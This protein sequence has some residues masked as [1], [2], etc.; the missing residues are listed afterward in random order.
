MIWYLPKVYSNI[1]CETNEMQLHLSNQPGKATHVTAKVPFDTGY[2]TCIHNAFC[3]EF[4]SIIIITC[5]TC[6]CVSTYVRL[7][8]KCTYVL[9]LSNLHCTGF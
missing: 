5:I 1:I 3:I 6:M 4:Y 8:L 2:V 7:L 9:L